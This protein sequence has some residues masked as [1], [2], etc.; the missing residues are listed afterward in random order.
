MR[1]IPDPQNPSQ[2]KISYVENVWEMYLYMQ[3][4]KVALPCTDMISQEPDIFRNCSHY[5][6]KRVVTFHGGSGSR[7]TPQK[8]RF[9]P[10]STLF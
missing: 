7:F 6:P 5:M 4:A 3:V 9:N 1:I 10:I 2:K 8:F